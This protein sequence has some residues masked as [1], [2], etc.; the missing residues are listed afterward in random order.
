MR[1]LPHTP[2]EIRTMLA[3]VGVEGM[4]D[5]FE[6]IPGPVRLNRPLD[7]EPALDEPRLMDHL[8]ALSDASAGPNMLSFLGGGMYRHHVPPA[9]D[10]LLQRSEFYT[11]YTPYQA[12]LSQGTLQAIFEFQT[13]VCELLGTDVANASM[14]DGASGVAEAALMARRIKRRTH[15]LLSEGLHP[16][17]IETIR[18]YLSGL[19]SEVTIQLVPL[20][21]DGRTDWQAAKDLATGK[22]AA[23]VV[24]YPNFLGCVEDLNAA[25]ALADS[26]DALLITA[27][28]EPYA[29]SV[30]QAPG[31]CGADI[32][33][34]EGQALAVPPQYGGPG[35]GLFGASQAFVRQMP[36]RLVGRTVDQ[37]GQPG[38]VLTLSTREQHIRREKATSN[39]CTNHG[40][41]AL[42]MGIRTAMLGR[43]GFQQ[44]GRRCLNAA[45]YIRAGVEKLD[46]FEVPYAAPTFNEL[47]IR[48]KGPDASE[49]LARLA[50]RGIIGGIDLGRFRDDWRKDLLVAVTELH[51]RENLD[52][53]LAAL[54]A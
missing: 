49:V 23:V 10:Q 51:T 15:L 41:I 14:Y 13:I 44:A 6:A 8:T 18:T 47:A 46:A 52:Q 30:L 26:E 4:D 50:D 31:A 3:R 29:L 37:E 11:A 27:T 16:E 42:A 53:L 36:G 5:L 22:T 17:Y 2:Q 24:G 39:I 34:G 1:Y 38:Y 12:E 9:V 40:L 45:S 21:A 19:D 35:V 33:V 7:L 48:S 28:A 54:A 32:C 25:R 20:A 43:Q